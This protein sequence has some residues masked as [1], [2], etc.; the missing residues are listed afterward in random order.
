MVYTGIYH[1]EDLMLL[2]EKVCKCLESNKIPYAIVGGF[3][4][5]LHGAPRGTID[6]DFI[7]RFEEACFVGVE[8]ALRSIGMESRLPVTG[9]EVFQFRKEYIEKRN[10]I[11]WSFYNPR[12]PIEIIDI[13]ITENLAD[14]AVIEKKVAHSRVKVL[15]KKDL[16]KMKKKGGRPQDLVDVEV[17]ERL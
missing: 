17:L 6:I 5:A 12:N 9:R 7:I 13:I 4:V 3:A 2:L 1:K 14:C 11:A 15:S 8:R 16:I 10:L